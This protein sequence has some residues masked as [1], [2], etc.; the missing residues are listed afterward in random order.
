MRA[1]VFVGPTLRVTE[2]PPVAGLVA[3]PPVAQGDVYRAARRRPRAIGIIDGYFEGVPSVWHKEILWAMAQGIHVFGSASMGAL[4]AAELCDFGMQ[5]SGLIFEAY[6]TNRLSPYAGPFEDDDE[7]AVIHGPPETGYVALSEA[8]V[9]IRATLAQAEQ[10]SVVEASTRDALAALAKGLYYHERSYE[11]LLVLAAEASLPAP[12]IAALRAW[13]PHGRIDQKRLDAQAMLAAMAALLAGDAAPKQVDYE[14]E[15]TEAWDDA[16]LA[17]A[18]ASIG[19]GEDAMWLSGE[20]ILD[21]LRL[22]SAAYGAA[23]DRALLRLLAER[24]AVRRHRLPTRASQRAALDRLRARHGLFRRADLDRWLAASDL[25]APQLEQLMA[26]EAQ[27]EGLVAQ[28]S[29]RL[30]HRLLDDLRLHGDYL[31]LAERA[32]SKQEFLETRGLDYP[33]PDDPHLP[34]PAVVRA[35]YFEQRL[36]QPLPDDIDAAA[37]E[38]GFAD[39]ADFDRALR[40]EWL[41]SRHRNT[42]GEDDASDCPVNDANR[43][44]C[45]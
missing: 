41:F 40:R 32:R 21:E 10:D 29:D 36:G 23:R 43:E 39:R 33:D 8:M 42:R 6:R 45:I 11:R 30:D 38:L 15:W 37:R 22:D 44:G 13:L 1:C 20:R 12:Q 27:L 9:N 18:G 5:G 25:D 7:V 19:R 3:L 14:L 28:E 35:W 2:L 26:A 16:T 24:E 34:P 4:R 31:H 17:A